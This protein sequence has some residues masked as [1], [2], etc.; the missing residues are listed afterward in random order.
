[1]YLQRLSFRNL[2]VYYTSYFFHFKKL[3]DKQKRI[4]TLYPF[5]WKKAQTFFFLRQRQKIRKRSFIKQY[6]FRKK[7][8]VFG[9]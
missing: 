8:K 3:K 1:M 2:H 6:N 7:Q 9:Y 4:F 5:F